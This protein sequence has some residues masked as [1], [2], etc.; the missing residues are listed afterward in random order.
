MKRVT[1]SVA[2]ISTLLATMLLA[3]CSNNKE[4]AGESS[5]ANTATASSS[6]SAEPVSNDPLGKYPEPVTV[7]QVLGFR[8]PEEAD[9]LQGV[10]PETNGYIKD[11]KEML[12]IELKYKWTVPSDQFDQKFNLAI[13]SGD[14][15]DMMMVDYNTF[16]KFKEQ[17]IL[18]DLS[19]AYQNYASPTLRK[20]IESDGGF[21]LKAM[22]SDN[23]LLGLA[24]SGEGGVQV[25]WIRKDWLDNLGLQAPTSIEELE[26]VADAFVKNDPDKNGKNDTYGLAL[27]KNFAAGW[28]FDAKGFFQ[29]SGSYPFAWL[30]GADGKLIPGEIQPETKAALARL[31]S[32]YQSGILEK[33]FA[34]KDEDKESEDL[35]AGKVGISFGEWWYP[36][37]PL[38]LNKDKD[39][40]ADWIQLELP[41]LNGN[42]GKTLISRGIGAI[43]VVKK[44]FEHPEA[45]IKMA[46][47]F[48]E[49]QKP[50][51]VD[52]NS[53]DFK[54]PK[55]GYNYS[56]YQP[57]YYSGFKDIFLAVNEALDANK[58]KLELPEDFIGSGEAQTWF[59]AAKKY[60]ANPKDNTAWGMYYSRVAKD[61]GI[62]VAEK[63]KE[64]KSKFVYNEYYGPP[65]PTQVEK[66]ASLNKLTNETF[67]KIIMGSAQISEFDKYVEDWKKLGGDDITREVNEWY[68][69]NA[70]K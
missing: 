46:N 39:P 3:A 63:I 67:T 2:L 26:K 55:T 4:T 31:Q 57:R 47:F 41:S 16:V 65:T 24:S 17:G 29:S 58:E 27:N 37:W 53:P 60:Q 40:K 23:K 45:A 49:L 36:N 62:A 66:G 15:P 12:N 6:Q 64:D 32:W 18:A 54:G 56:W 42:P 14:L 69:K 50:K 22:T 19:E 28:G 61:G 52:K 35:V 9:A 59:D 10:T 20:I 43:M 25:L 30:K 38:N 8:P 7:T 48:Q 44:D 34:L 51:Y 1:T 33:E 11:L 13:A 5:P 21:A 68:D 70:V